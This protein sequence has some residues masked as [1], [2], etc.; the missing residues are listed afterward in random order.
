MSGVRERDD[1]IADR[2]LQLPWCTLIVPQP[3]TTTVAV[4]WRWWRESVSKEKKRLFQRTRQKKKRVRNQIQEAIY[5]KTRAVALKTAFYFYI[6]VFLSC[7]Y[8]PTKTKPTNKIS[9]F[10]A[11]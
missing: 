3:S 7:C 11:V 6:L 9:L 8:I 10:G 1:A 5:F 2:L 4:Y